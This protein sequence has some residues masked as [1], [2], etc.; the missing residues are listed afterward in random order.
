MRAIASRVPEPC[1]RRISGTSRASRS[2]SLP[3]ART[4][5][6]QAD[7]HDLVAPEE[8]R[9][10]PSVAR[11]WPTNARSHSRASKLVVARSE[12]EIRAHLDARA[13]R[14]EFR[15][16]RRQQVFPGNREARARAPDLAELVGAQSRL[17]SSCSATM[18]RA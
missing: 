6:D 7:E 1:S 4:R 15:E 16:Q 11:L 3:W 9:H 14:A 2:V 10:E 5:R 12:S 17:A 18:R 8:L 13:P